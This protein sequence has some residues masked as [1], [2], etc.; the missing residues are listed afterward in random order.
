[1]K[2]NFYFIII[3]LLTSLC[4]HSQVPKSICVK[5]GLSYAYMYADNDKIYDYPG[6]FYVGANLDFFHHKNFSLLIEGGFVTK[7]DHFVYI[8]P[9]FKTRWEFGRFIPFLY[10]GPRLDFVL[11]TKPQRD[12]GANDIYNFC[13]FGLASGIGL[14]YHF[15]PF[16]FVLGFANQFDITK[17]LN[18]DKLSPDAVNYNHNTLILS[19]GM[20]AY[21]GTKREY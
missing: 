2:K 14:E 18:E 1:M 15:F 21:F 6:S 7:S 20:K 5:P 4:L 10:A 9:M 12:S 13:V 16:G 17:V 3:L 11:L 19:I 8:S